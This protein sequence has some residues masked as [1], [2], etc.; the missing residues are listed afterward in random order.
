MSW[1]VLPKALHCYAKML[2]GTMQADPDGGQ[3]DAGERCD[4][5]ARHLLE[6]EQNQHLPILVR[7]RVEDRI[8]SRE[9]LAPLDV[10]G[11]A[12]PGSDQHVVEL[13][14][15]G[16]P[17]PA[18]EPLLAPAVAHDSFRD[19][20]EPRRRLRLSAKLREATADDDEDLVHRVFD[21]DGGATEVRGP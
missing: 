20:I 4:V 6:L 7:H 13:I 8:D 1:R 18:P 17:N 3:L 16:H 15:L 5:L 2:P 9:L 12:R 19:P 11:W 14:A 21:V 10:L